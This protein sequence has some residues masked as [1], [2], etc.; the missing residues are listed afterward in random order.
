MQALRLSW[1]NIGLAPLA[2]VFV[3]LVCLAAGPARADKAAEQYVQDRADEVMAIINNSSYSTAKKKAEISD[4]IDEFI[5]VE[6]IAMFTLGKYRSQV[7]D[8]E[9]DDY[10]AAFREYLINYYVGQLSQFEGVTLKVTGSQDD[11]RKGTLVSSIAA[12][13]NGEPT[14]IDWQ[15]ASGTSIVDVSI[16]GVSMAQTLREQV[17]STIDQ[18]DGQISPAIDLLHQLANEG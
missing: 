15:V 18:N 7:G 10:V 5:D 13:D 4:I 1:L 9:R 16:A 17:V 2:A 12:T 6:R 8:S 14:E 11:A 3:A